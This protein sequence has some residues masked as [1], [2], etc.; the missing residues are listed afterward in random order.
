LVTAAMAIMVVVSGAIGAIRYEGLCSLDVQVFSV[1]D[2]VVGYLV[3]ALGVGRIPITLTCPLGFLERSLALRMLLPQWSLSVA[4]L[5][6]SV[7]LLGRVFCAWICPAVLVGRSSSGAK[8]SNSNR[9]DAPAASSWTSYSSYAVLGGVLLASFLFRF[10]VF[11]LFCPIGLFFGWLYSLSRLLAPESPGME[12]LIFPA[13]L[14]LEVWILRKHWCRSICP[15]G[16]LLSVFGNLNRFFV[17]SVRKEKCLTSKGV[18]CGICQRACSE[19][20]DLSKIRTSFAPQSCTK[21][22]ECYQKCPT[23]AIEIPILK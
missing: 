5:L 17:P 19:R 23:G 12:L 18:A 21:C 1:A 13:M 22:L 2:P 7:V 20:I 4:I 11:C 3:S 9:V 8:A 14:A 6:L 10:P 15:L 16:A